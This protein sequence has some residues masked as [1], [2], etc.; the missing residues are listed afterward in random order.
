[1][2]A[3]GRLMLYAG[4]PIRSPAT[5]P[6]DGSDF[7]GVPRYQMRPVPMCWD[8]AMGCYLTHEFAAVDDLSCWMEPRHE[9]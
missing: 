3:V 6:R 4:H 7:L 2:S 1:M 8:A 9:H 5:A